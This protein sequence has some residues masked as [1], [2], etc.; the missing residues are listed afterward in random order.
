MRH[1][2]PASRKRWWLIA[3]DPDSDW[4]YVDVYEGDEMQ[5]AERYMSHVLKDR[6]SVV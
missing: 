1:L 5:A 6:K 3:N 4:V 2:S